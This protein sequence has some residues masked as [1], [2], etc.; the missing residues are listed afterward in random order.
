[1]IVADNA[2]A[3]HSISSLFDIWNSEVGAVEDEV[4]L[5]GK[6]RFFTDPRD[7]W[8]NNGVLPCIAK[9][10]ELSFNSI[11]WV[12]SESQ[13]RQSWI[14]EFSLDL[15]RVARSKRQMLTFA[16]CDRPLGVR[17]T[18]EIVMKQLVCQLLHMN[19]VL[20]IEE[21]EL[22]NSRAF[23][24]ANGFASTAQLLNSIVARLD[25]LLIVID[26]IDLCQRDHKSPGDQ[27]IIQALS[28]MT[29]RYS[30]SLKTII[31]SGGVANSEELSRLGISLAIINTRKRPHRR[32]GDSAKLQ[33]REVLR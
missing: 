16:L 21:P 11:L 25:S 32:Y 18:S 24:R 22:F 23:R 33:R 12:S 20:A 27:N 15:L 4:Q 31:T 5:W 10:N 14:T 1:M 3:R 6:P 26:R 8:S 7:H 2:S 19:P 17:W 13:G 9:W 29:K 30:K 28:K